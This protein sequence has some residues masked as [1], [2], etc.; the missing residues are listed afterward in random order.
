MRGME[1]KEVINILRY[2]VAAYPNFELTDERIKVWID[3]MKD[4]SYEKTMDK[5]KQHCKTIK[6]P[7]SV[8]EIVVNE[9]PVNKQMN[10]L[11]EWEEVARRDKEHRND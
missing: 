1:S 4:G 6:F 10:K 2:I 3:L 5:L 9:M 7:P 11:K 8:A